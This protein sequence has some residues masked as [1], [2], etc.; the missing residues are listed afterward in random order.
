M[1]HTAHTVHPSGHG[2]A[3]A[4]TNG[5][6]RFCATCEPPRHTVP[7]DLS[8]YTMSPVLLAA[9]NVD[10]LEG[11]PTPSKQLLYDSMIPR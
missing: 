4:V 11:P 9:R 2:S 5:L 3:Q 1:C 7:M 6:G 10:E 8:A